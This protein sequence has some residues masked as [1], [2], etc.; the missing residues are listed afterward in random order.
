[1]VSSVDIVANCRYLIRSS[2]CAS[3]C[4]LYLCLTVLNIHNLHFVSL[5]ILMV[6]FYRSL[7]C[8]SEQIFYFFTFSNNKQM[9][10][11]VCPFVVVIFLFIMYAVGECFS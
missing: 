9:A 10:H 5:L 6:A 8:Y 4:L 11:S 7:Y 3:F 2:F 1:M